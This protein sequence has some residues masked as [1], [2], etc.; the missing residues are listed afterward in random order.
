MSLDSMLFDLKEWI[1]KADVTY[2]KKGIYTGG[3]I[4]GGIPLSAIGDPDAYVQP[5]QEVAVLAEIPAGE[6]GTYFSSGGNK[7]Y[8]IRFSNKEKSHNYYLICD[9]KFV[10]IIN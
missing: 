7:C 3:K 9:T 6:T 1:N 10:T 5:N 2:P 4:D 8:F